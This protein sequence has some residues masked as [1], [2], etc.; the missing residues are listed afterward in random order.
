MLRRF[1]DLEAISKVLKIF[2]LLYLSD[3]ICLFFYLWRCSK[4][5][6][7]ILQKMRPDVNEIWQ[8]QRAGCH[9][10]RRKVL[11]HGVSC[12]F[13]DLLH[14]QDLGRERNDQENP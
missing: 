14:E 3:K 12:R 4:S 9:Q 13:E 2:R 1:L 11:I 7:L 5:I 10:M 8:V 6:L